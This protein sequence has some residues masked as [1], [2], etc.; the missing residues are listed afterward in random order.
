[1]GLFLITCSPDDMDELSV[2]PPVVEEKE[3]ETTEPAE[4]TWMTMEIPADPGAG[5]T[6]EFQEGPSDDFEYLAPAENKG[7]AFLSK[8]DDFYHNAWTGPGLTIWER[9]N[10]LVKDGLLQLPSNRASNGKNIN[11][12]CITST[13]RVVYPVYVEVSA[14]V[15][16]STLSSGV[17][18]LSP[19]DTQE[20]DILEAYGSSYSESAQKDHSWFAERIHISHHVFVRDPFL[21]YQPT[22][23][24]SWYNDGTVWREEFHRYG[25]YWRDPWHLE[26]YIDGALVRTVT[27]KDLIDPKHYTNTVDPGNTQSDTRSGLNKEMDIIIDVEDQDWRS[28]PASGLQADTYTPTDA[29]LTN[30]ED[31]TFKVEWIRIY[32]PVSQ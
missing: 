23:S 3:D 29:E 15:M 2:T 31:H 25:V 32:K 9:D 13:N 17:W 6:W 20:I 10:S 5:M 18:L 16:N 7:N 14:K 19:D 26:Y 24:G 4:E 27:G 11:A 1:M 8:W 21:D 22:D 30:T 28:E 12:G